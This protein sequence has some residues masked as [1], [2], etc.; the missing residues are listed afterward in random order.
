MAKPKTNK[1][2]KTTCAATGA[3]YTVRPAVWEKRLERFGVDSET[4]VQNY[5]SR[6]A[7]KMIKEAENPSNM[8]LELQSRNKIPQKALLE[9]IWNEYISSNKVDDDI[10][11]I[12]EVGET[13]EGK[14][15]AI[16]T[17]EV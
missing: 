8:L 11:A 12:I 17:V 6:S 14:V 5:L 2:Y 10:K 7:L 1:V 3:S 15:E 9:S 16:E 13:V 4:L